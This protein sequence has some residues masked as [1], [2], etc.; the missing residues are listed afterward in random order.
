MKFTIK[1]K[2]F[3]RQNIKIGVADIKNNATIKNLKY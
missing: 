2:F 3:T 1:S